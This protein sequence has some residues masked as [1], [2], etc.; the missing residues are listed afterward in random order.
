MNLDN[1]PC[2][3]AKMRGLYGR[4]HLPVAPRCNIQCNYCDRKYDCVNESRP[5]VTSAV[6]SPHQAMTYLEYVLEEVKNISVV[7]IAGPGDPFANPD[8]TMETLRLVRERYPEMILCLATNGLGIGPYIDEL[9][10][11]NVSHV[12]ITLNAID[13]EIGSKLYAFVRHGKKVLA[14]ETGFNVLL[15]KQ[16]EA[17]IRLKE[18][19]VTTKVNTIV[20]PGI[21]DTHIEAV[22]RKMSEL[23]V[24]ILNCIPFFPNKGAAFA[25]IEEPTKEM[26]NQIRKAAAQYI[27]QMTH[28]KRCR[29][30]AVGILGQANNCSIDEKL[31]E[32]AELPEIYDEKRPYVAVASLEG[33]L[34]NQKLGKAEELY[35]YGRRDNGEIYLVETRK[36]PEPGGGMQR[37]EDLSEI[38]SDC[39]ALLVAGI[40]DNPRRTLSKKKIDILELDGMIEDAAEAVF[41]GHSM[42]F[43]VR[44]DIVACNKQHPMAGMGCM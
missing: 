2:F 7:G 4:V 38:I 22:A 12:T 15:E 42:N 27:P 20:V 40:G 19:N 6:L 16:L 21:N 5:G 10:E 32:C 39:R 3:N 23:R 36:T 41:E 11:M 34:V 35:I 37:W 17:I 14:P 43:M 30:D 29:A 8:E 9:S 25:N 24:D 26:V 31:R 28:C 13:P 33:V 18:K 44:R 1:H